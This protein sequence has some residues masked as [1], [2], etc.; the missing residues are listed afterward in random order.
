[1]LAIKLID[2]EP[3][4]P[5][6]LAATIAK[7]PGFDARKI[8]RKAVKHWATLRHMMVDMHGRPGGEIRALNP[9]NAPL[10]PGRARPHGLPQL[11]EMRGPSPYEVDGSGPGDWVDLG[12]GARGRDV[13]DLII[14]LSGGADRRLVEV[15][16]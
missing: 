10:E 4:A 1:M 15:S 9:A 11:R 7:K 3:A 12:T 13:I 16:A 14:Y 5:A 6:A 8:N 2:D